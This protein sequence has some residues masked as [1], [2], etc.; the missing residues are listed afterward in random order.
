MIVRRIFWTLALTTL[1]ATLAL[2]HSGG[3]DANG[4]HNDRKSGGYHFHRG[5]L[6]GQ[7]F[8]SKSEAQKAL[9]R[10]AVAT[11]ATSESRGQKASA[12]ERLD[13]LTRL[14]V[15]KGIITEEEIAKEIST[16]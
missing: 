4:G 16:R 5:P 12:E 6:A 10:S 14:L 8:S 3:L 7:S 1:M 13:A 2:A 9:E 15:R 11:Q